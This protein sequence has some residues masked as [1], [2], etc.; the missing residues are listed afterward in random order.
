MIQFHSPATLSPPPSQN[1]LDHSPTAHTLRTLSYALIQALNDLPSP[2]AY[3]FTDK[4][5]SPHFAMYNSGGHECVLPHVQTRRQQLENIIALRKVHP[6]WKLRIYHLSAVVERG[7]EEGS[8]LYTSLGEG[9]P[10]SEVFNR[11]QEMVGRLSWRRRG[12]DGVWECFMHEGI[13]GG[14]DFYS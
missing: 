4:H 9:G 11:Q 2:S 3:A 10:G 5:M 1:N 13:R 7:G 8:V 14:G 6:E 12:Q